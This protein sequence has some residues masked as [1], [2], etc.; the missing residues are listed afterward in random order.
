METNTNSINL[1]IFTQETKNMCLCTATSIMI[2]ILFVISPLSNFFKTSLFM[3][4]LAMGLMTYIIFLNY[5]QTDL[6]RS[7]ISN[8]DSLAV[9]SQLNINILCSYIFTFFIGLL[10]IFVFKSMI[11]S[12]F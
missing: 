5:K 1:S 8:A 4:I 11:I 3:K 9:K 6:L 2:I 10:I 7:A 12:F